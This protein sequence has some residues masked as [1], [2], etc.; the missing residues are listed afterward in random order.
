MLLDE[1]RAG[2]V[3]RLCNCRDTTAART[4]LA[5]A[6]L[7][8]THTRI[9]AL[10]EDKFWE[11]LQKDLDAIAKGAS[12]LENRE[13]RAKLEAVVKAAQA[14]IAR[15]RDRATEELDPHP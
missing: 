2:L 8:L 15:Y 1:Y 6:H 10:T 9:T 14:R 3:D 13:A 5:E 7:V 11:T 4:L 12:G